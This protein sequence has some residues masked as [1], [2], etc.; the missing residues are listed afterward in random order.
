[1]DW[2]SL[3]DELW[4]LR[5][6]L[7]EMEPVCSVLPLPERRGLDALADLHESELDALGA[8]DEWLQGHAP[9]YAIGPGAKILDLRLEAGANLARELAALGTP[10]PAGWTRRQ[11]LRFL[12]RDLFAAAM[13]PLLDRMW[14]ES[15]GLLEDGR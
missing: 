8:F 4:T 13:Q 2:E 3:A 15:H 9:L 7:T 11:G 14:L 1:M 5:G 6:A 10:V 12:V